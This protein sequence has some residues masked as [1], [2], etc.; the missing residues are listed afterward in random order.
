MSTTAKILVFRQLATYLWVLKLDYELCCYVCN[1][2]MSAKAGI[3]VATVFAT[4]LTRVL[5][6]SWNK[7]IKKTFLQTQT[8]QNRC[9][10][11][12]FYMFCLSIKQPKIREEAAAFSATLSLSLSLSL[13]LFLSL[14]RDNIWLDK[15][16]CRK[17]LENRAL[18]VPE[19]ATLV[20]L[21]LYKS[22]HIF[23]LAHPSTYVCM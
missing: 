1:L 19:M 23:T 14:A 16:K 7:H 21:S 15:R 12:V 2:P 11:E 13:S 10:N 3:W 17:S 22:Q 5:S 9:L 8:K 18:C 6:I 4:F 20:H